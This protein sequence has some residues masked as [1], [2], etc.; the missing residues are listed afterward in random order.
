MQSCGA[1]VAWMGPVLE[2]VEQ[3]AGGPLAIDGSCAVL[4]VGNC[5]H[6]AR[7]G[8]ALVCCM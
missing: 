4:E 8:A 7:S 5:W 6:A 1:V 2:M 3:T